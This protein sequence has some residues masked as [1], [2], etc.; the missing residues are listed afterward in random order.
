MSVDASLILHGHRHVEGLTR[1]SI[2]SHLA[3]DG[4]AVGD[5][6]RDIYVLSCPSS[7]GHGG[8]DAGFNVI[9]FIQHLII[10]DCNM[11]LK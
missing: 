2:P 10:A 7:T 3:S 1:Y 4:E 9:H 8:D 5:F 11:S 6:W